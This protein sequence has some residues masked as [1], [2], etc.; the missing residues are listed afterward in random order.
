MT[1][2]K[3]RLISADEFKRQFYELGRKLAS[4]DNT[5]AVIVGTLLAPIR[6]RGKSDVLRRLIAL[7]AKEQALEKA[8]LDNVERMQIT[9]A[10]IDECPTLEAPKP[11]LKNKPWYGKFNKGRY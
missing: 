11:T 9:H 6:E 4:S 2:E 5:Q 1:Y 10:Y 7:L 3:F 8:W